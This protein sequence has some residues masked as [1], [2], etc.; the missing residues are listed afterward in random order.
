MVY[1]VDLHA[2]RLSQS[3]LRCDGNL[4]EFSEWRHFSSLIA[5]IANN[6]GDGYP[7]Y[8]PFVYKVIKFMLITCELIHI[9]LS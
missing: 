5:Q 1:L 4:E 7:F 8:Y 6:N 2:L 9:S 3:T